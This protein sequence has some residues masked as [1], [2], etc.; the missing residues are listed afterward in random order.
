[1][2]KK[3]YEYKDKPGVYQEGAT[4]PFGSEEAFIKAGGIKTENRQEGQPYWA[5]VEE[6]EPII[7]KVKSMLYTD[8]E[9]RSGT[10][11]NKT[12]GRS[13]GE[14]VSEQEAQAQLAAD[15]G[16][17]P[18][19][20]EW[21]RILAKGATGATGG[22]PGDTKDEPVDENAG[23]KD[24]MLKAMTDYLA[25]TGDQK[26]L[27][28][29]RKEE[30]EKLGISGQQD[31]VG[32]LQ[33]QILD[34]EGILDDLEGDV[35]ESVEG[36]MVSEGQRRRI[37]ASEMKPLTEQMTDLVRAETRAST[38]LTGSRAELADIMGLEEAERAGAKEKAFGM[39]PYYKEVL[40][41]ETKAEK[42]KRETQEAID[43]AKAIKESGLEEKDTKIEVVNGRK[44]LFNMQTG[45]VIKDL[46]KDTSGTSP[47]SITVGGQLGLSTSLATKFDTDL[48]EEY[49]A[50]YSGE[51]GIEGAR[52]R[53]LKNLM[54]NPRYQSVKDKISD[55]IYGSDKFNAVFP[56]GYESEIAG[57]GTE[58]RW[59][60]ET[61]GSIATGYVDEVGKD[62][63]RSLIEAGIININDKDYTL[64]EKEKQML[65]KMIEES[66]EETK[67]KWKWP[68]TT[69]LGK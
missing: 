20:I 43:E 29:I 2:A 10:I 41:Y 63:A 32:G 4:T 65:L 26:S 3:F 33:R 40:E 24:L 49:K 66:E 35:N 28:E 47:G 52:E 58:V 59:D 9:D 45:D 57:K 53:A 12:T 27:T 51:Y 42:A 60:D 7:N 11:F 14:G 22:T 36:K 25:K 1:M 46:G 23:Y 37:L 34:V 62:K 50:V 15:L 55:V 17:R 19:E 30:S 56:D 38:G 68:F 6:R 5:N 67:H 61:L 48:E 69:P 39:L 64:S 16:K 44:I 31:I 8:L 21:D 54:A 18:D 13:Y